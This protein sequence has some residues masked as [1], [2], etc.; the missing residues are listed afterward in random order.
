M[1]KA[2]H[3]Q[4]DRSS[5]GPREG[6]HRPRF[7]A[8]PSDDLVLAVLWILVVLGLLLLALFLIPTLSSRMDAQ[9]SPQS[10]SRLI[11]MPDL[12]QLHVSADTP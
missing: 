3:P 11:V 4:K 8:L 6:T 10:Q 12:P 2:S 7:R 5:G 1:A 9:V